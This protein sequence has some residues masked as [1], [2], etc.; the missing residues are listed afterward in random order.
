MTEPRGTRP[1]CT[2]REISWSSAQWTVQSSIAVRI[3]PQPAAASLDL[4]WIKKQSRAATWGHD[5]CISTSLES[6][7]CRCRHALPALL[8]R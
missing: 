7:R 3:A 2:L 8:S 1:D 4:R 6:L 5:C